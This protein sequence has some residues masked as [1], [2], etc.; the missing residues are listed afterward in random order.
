MIEL[1]INIGKLSL[2]SQGASPI[3]CAE[4]TLGIHKLLEVVAEADH[5]TFDE[6]LQKVTMLVQ[7]ARKLGKDKK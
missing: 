7:T 1:K 3:V 5:C 4:A 6:A 2:Q